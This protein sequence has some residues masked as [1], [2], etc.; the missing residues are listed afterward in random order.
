MN[1]SAS[2]IPDTITPNAG[3][4][5]NALLGSIISGVSTIREST[6][7]IRLKLSFKSYNANMP[8]TIISFRKGY[9]VTTHTNA[10]N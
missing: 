9:P 1:I 5:M 6:T 8:V 4:T 7:T 10:D 3:V 2:D